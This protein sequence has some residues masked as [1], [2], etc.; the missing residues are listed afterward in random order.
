M[1]SYIELPNVAVVKGDIYSIKR[2]K[3]VSCAMQHINLPS[4]IPRPSRYVD[5]ITLHCPQQRQLF[6]HVYTRTYIQYVHMEGESLVIGGAD[7]MAL[8]LSRQKT[9]C[10]KAYTCTC[11]YMYIHVRTYNYTC[12]RNRNSTCLYSLCD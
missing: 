12:T 5:T 11:I 7:L 3:H 10:L 4:L 8:Q 1:S 2:N 6:T 9:T